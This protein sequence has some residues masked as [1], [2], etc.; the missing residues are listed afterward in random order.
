MPRGP[1]GATRG[2]TLE[3]PVCGQTIK[4]RHPDQFRQHVGK[5]CPD[6]V[7]HVPR[8]AWGDTASA[9]A[10]VAEHEASLLRTAKGLAYAP[11][12][13]M[14]VAEVAERM[15]LPPRRVK[16]LLRRASKA[17]PLVADDAPLDVVFEDAD[18]L[19]V[20]KPPGLR[21][22]PTHRFEGNSLLSRCLGHVRRRA[23]EGND[24]ERLEDDADAPRVVHRLDMDTS[25]VCL[26]VKDAT[27]A[28][29]FARQFRDEREAAPF[30][31]ASKEY[32]ALCVGHVPRPTR[33]GESAVVRF[34][35]ESAG[36]AP[37]RVSSSE[38]ER[39]TNILEK[40]NGFEKETSFTSFT[41]DAHV[42]AHASIAEARWVHPPPPPDP[43][44]K[45]GGHP[46]MDAS[47]P[48]HAETV[49]AVLSETPF[50]AET[51]RNR[52]NETEKK[53][54]PKT[55]AENDDSRSASRLVAALVRARPLTG[56]TH[57]IRVHLAHASL[58]ILSDPLYGPHVRWGGAAPAEN[59]GDADAAF[60]G[61]DAAFGGGGETETGWGGELWL[62]RQA[63]HAQRLTVTHP[64]TLEKLVFDAPMPED[65]RRA[66]EALGVDPRAAE[67]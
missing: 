25:G 67:A 63:L 59:R 2:P 1:R 23:G 13:R 66:C 50:A 65:M 9:A 24:D 6:V 56:R 21:F 42:G 48:K 45:L 61:A 8:D 49:C 58:P 36:D 39:K 32:L 7:E 41:V 4:A 10:A 5:C 16:A 15:S 11:G 34:E 47:L 27:L 17:I 12:S 20:N 57:Q 22:H 55:L 26:F 30:A 43:N 46:D 64:R 38:K 19:V 54:V 60:G 28:D 33:G 52:K 31:R 62:G 29:G 14:P 40:E 3:C 18:L 51:R 44:A 35:G 53:K 37:R